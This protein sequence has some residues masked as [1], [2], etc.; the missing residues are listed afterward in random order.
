[1]FC[2]FEILQRPFYVNNDRPR[3][4]K[5][6]YWTNPF[7]YAQT[8]N[9]IW[10]CFG[11]WVFSGYS[12]LFPHEWPPH[13]KIRQMR[14]KNIYIYNLKNLFINHW[15]SSKVQVTLDFARHFQSQQHLNVKHATTRKIGPFFVQL[16]RVQVFGLV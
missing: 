7:K 9:I 8:L 3:W 10:Y 4:R 13:A 12:G 2:S 15:K 16:C 14:N 11:T 1:M 5:V 6:K